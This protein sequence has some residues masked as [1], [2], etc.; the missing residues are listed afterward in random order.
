MLGGGKENHPF[1]CVP[2]SIELGGRLAVLE[3]V[4]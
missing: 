2:V 3:I 4:E 1:A